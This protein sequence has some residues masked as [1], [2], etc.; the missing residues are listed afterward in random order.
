MSQVFVE[1]Q[2]PVGK[3]DVAIMER[4]LDEITDT[5]PFNRWFKLWA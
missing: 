5:A 4:L 1:F 3:P 2:Y